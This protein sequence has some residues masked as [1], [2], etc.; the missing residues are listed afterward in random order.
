MVKKFKHAIKKEVVYYL[1]TLLALA[2][3]M[4]SDLLNDPFL[5]F[6]NMSEKGN[7]SHPFLYSL[8]I[9]GTILI[10]RKTIDFIIG[11]F[12]KKAL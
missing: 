6:H 2:L 10:L 5:R 1:L 12:E 3:I 11:L 7:F 9:Y 4:H 8:V